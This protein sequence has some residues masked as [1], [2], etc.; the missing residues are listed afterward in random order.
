MS[1]VT[2][3]EY[4]C[5]SGH[6]IAHRHQLDA[7]LAYIDGQPCAGRLRRIGAGSRGG[8]VK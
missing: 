8:T 7:C 4:L 5:S 3:V 1:A 6:Y 2:A